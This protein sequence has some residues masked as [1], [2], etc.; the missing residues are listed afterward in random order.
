MACSVEEHIE[1]RELSISTLFRQL[2]TSPT[3]ADPER[4]RRSATI[5]SHHTLEKA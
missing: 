3:R 1:T 4:N 2:V 5:D